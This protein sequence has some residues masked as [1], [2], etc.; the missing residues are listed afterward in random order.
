MTDKVFIRDRLII[1]A[2]AGSLTVVYEA[3]PLV[4]GATAAVSYR[5]DGGERSLSILGRG[6]AYGVGLRPEEAVSLSRTNDELQLDWHIALDDEVEMWLEVTNVGQKPLQV[7]ELHVLAVDAAQRGK[8]ELGS[9]LRQWSFYQNGWQSWSPAFARHVD[10]GLYVDPNTKDY[11]TKHQP[12]YRSGQGDVFS[13]EWF[14]VLARVGESRRAKGRCLLLGFITTKEQLAEVRLSL[15]NDG[16]ERLA[17]VCYADGVTL[18]PGERLFSERLVVAQGEEPFGLLEAYAQRLGQVMKARQRTALPTGWCSWYYFFRE[19][20]GADVLDNV[21]AIEKEA[22]PLEYI[23]VDDG[24][25]TAI[26]DWLSVDDAKFADMRGLVQEIVRAG[27]KPGIWTAPF[28]ASSDSQL[29]A[30]HPDWVIRDEDGQPLVAW[31]HWGVDTYGLDLSHPEVQE[32]LR[33]TFRTIRG[34]WGYE[35]FKVDF[36]FAGGLAGRRHNPQMSRAQVMRKGLEIIRQAIGEGAFLLGCGAPLGPSIGLVDAMRIGPDMAANWHPFWGDLS[37]PAAENAL[38]NVVTRYFLH[39]ALWLSDPDCLLVRTRD[40][41]SNLVLNEMRTM[42]SIIGL[43]G[44]I[45]LSSDNLSSIRRGRLKYLRR[46]LPPYGR[47]AIPLDLFEREMPGLLVLPVETD[48]GQWLVV[49]LVNWADRTTETTIELTDLDL[50]RGRYHVYN[51]WRRRYLGTIEDRLTIK[52]HQ[53]HETVLLLIKPVSDRPELLTS[54]FHVTQGGVEV[55]GIEWHGTWE[56]GRTL[57]VELEKAGEQ[58]GGL[59]FTVPE[60]YRVTEIRLDG[61]RRGFKWVDREVIG[62]GFSLRDRARVELD[63]ESQS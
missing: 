23:V 56:G 20:T 17:A 28:G 19:V 40:D 62:L 34:E 54:T 18:E 8:I 1:D 33:E 42:A 24:Y 10:G 22:L 26:G 61:R 32:W 53:P 35:L 47:A 21:A 7:D 25:Q 55:S 41:E 29:Y 49:G 36:V 5:S 57:V 44:G 16:G 4:S 2:E 58:R 15:D 60:L 51:Y 50:P 46:V 3:V 30:E 63:F 27:Y 38:R 12:H 6:M 39:G 37:L 14:T 45:V 59:L 52:R 11:Q 43:C 31:Q 48:W 9:P 13:S